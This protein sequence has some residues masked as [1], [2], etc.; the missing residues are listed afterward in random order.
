MRLFSQVPSSKR[1]ADLVI[2]GQVDRVLTRLENAKKNMC[3]CQDKRR[4]ANNWRRQQ[5]QPQKKND[6]TNHP[7]STMKK[8]T[9]YF[10]REFSSGRRERN[11]LV[12]AQT[13]QF[14]LPTG[15]VLVR[16]SNSLIPYYS[17]YIHTCIPVVP[18][19]M[20][21]IIKKKKTAG[22]H[23]H[24]HTCTRIICSSI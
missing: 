2:S 13:T 10:S 20:V 24:T 19:Y 15:A 9:K 11:S 3:N 16:V 1:I 23:T 5:R 21:R 8:K 22:R 4:A 17:A 18:F 6:E 7:N 14:V 12:I